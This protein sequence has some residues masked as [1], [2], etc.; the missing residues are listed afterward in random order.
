MDQTFCLHNSRE[1]LKHPGSSE[2]GIKPT[3]AQ[4][5]YPSPAPCKLDPISNHRITKESSLLCFLHTCFHYFTIL[6]YF[7][8]F[9]FILFY[10]PYYVPILYVQWKE[11]DRGRLL[12]DHFEC[13]QKIPG[14]LILL[15][16]CWA[17]F[18]HHYGFYIDNYYLQAEVNYLLSLTEKI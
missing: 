3:L 9:Y 7:I 6:F 1:A 16:P 10:F 5:S 11:G 2:I 15:L 4:P 12:T 17:V 14:L 13:F 18:L 8:L